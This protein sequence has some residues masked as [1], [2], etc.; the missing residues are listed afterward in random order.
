MLVER[1]QVA[2]WLLLG[3]VLG[4]FGDLHVMLALSQHC[5]V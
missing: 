4:R 3:H 5:T 1:K 2:D